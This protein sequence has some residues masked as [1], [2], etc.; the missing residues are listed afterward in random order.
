M[1]P[2]LHSL[3]PELLSDVTEYLAVEH[4]P[5]LHALSLAD[6][7]CC[8]VANGQRFR[9][10]H[11]HSQAESRLLMDINHWETVLERNNA[12]STVQRLSIDGTTP[13]AK[14]NTRALNKNGHLP[15]CLQKSFHTEDEWTDISRK[16]SHDWKVEGD[17]ELADMDNW[18]VLARFVRK[19][20]GL[21]EL[22][23]LARQRF[24]PSL[25]DILHKDLPRLDLSKESESYEYTLSTSPSLTSIVFE[26]KHAGTPGDFTERVLTKMAS[27]LAPN[28]TDV[29]VDYRRPH[30]TFSAFDKSVSLHREALFASQPQSPFRLCSLCLIDPEP[31]TIEIWNAG[32]QF[33]NLKKLELHVERRTGLLAKAAEYS[34]PSLKSLVLRLCERPPRGTPF[35]E[36]LLICGYV[37]V[38]STQTAISCHGQILHKLGLLYRY[39]GHPWCSRITPELLDD[40][41]AHCPKLRSL[42]LRISRTQG[43]AVEVGLYKALSR[44]TYLRDVVLHLD[45]QVPRRQN[46]Q[47]DL[48]D[49]KKILINLA[50]DK[51]LIRSIFDTLLPQLQDLGVF[52]PRPHFPEEDSFYRDDRNPSYWIEQGHDEK[53]FREFWP[54]TKRSSWVEDWRSFPLQL[55][56]GRR[57]RKNQ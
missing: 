36:R 32:V 57:D 25:L 7:F 55:N 24:P 26:I 42:A 3:P 50:I 28:L 22:F 5:S 12:L 41:H 1:S 40:I 29:Y 46:G 18:S 4:M 20:S 47:T 44:I 37:A 16:L 53:L 15:H 23:W 48:T 27:G 33:S 45:C 11:V 43:D 30:K 49:R 31:E 13:P 6:K 38:R 56:R 54:K 9:N 2:S 10:I 17:Y 51:T 14:S 39:N 34:F 19:L 8:A 52:R 21:T 35:L